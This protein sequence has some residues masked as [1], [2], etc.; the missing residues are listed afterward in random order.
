MFISQRQE[1][2]TNENKYSR[3]E[4]LQMGEATREK[5]KSDFL[6]RMK[7]NQF[8]TIKDYGMNQLFEN[9]A[10]G[11]DIRFRRFSK[12]GF[13][14]EAIEYYDR[15]KN[16][17]DK[18][19]YLNMKLRGETRLEKKGFNVAIVYPEKYLIQEIYL[20]RLEKH[21]SLSQVE[22]YQKIIDCGY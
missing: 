5:E 12:E 19:A 9:F 16:S 13:N 6:N 4:Y 11:I 21:G 15:L 3:E 8:D 1:T 10:K 17:D 18:M 22:S 2:S 14:L 20:M 7:Q